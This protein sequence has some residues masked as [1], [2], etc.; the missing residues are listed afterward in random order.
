MVSPSPRKSCALCVAAAARVPR[1]LPPPAQFPGSAPLSRRGLPKGRRSSRRSAARV[2]VSLGAW[3]AAER[4]SVRQLPSRGDEERRTS[5][6]KPAS[7]GRILRCASAPLRGATRIRPL[8]CSRSAPPVPPLSLSSRPWA[9]PEP[10]RR[11]RHAPTAYCAAGGAPCISNRHSRVMCS[12]L[13]SVGVMFTTTR[14]CPTGV[15][16]CPVIHLIRS[17]KVSWMLATS[18]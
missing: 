7:A 17:E 12:G 2:R 4:L 11:G 3:E 8:Q 5:S 13:P 10:S 14:A 1:V 18:P 9:L 6:P 15:S 16:P